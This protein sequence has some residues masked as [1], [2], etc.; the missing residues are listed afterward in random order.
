MLSN[1]A[2]RLIGVRSAAAPF[3]GCLAA[4]CDE[5]RRLAE[6]PRAETSERRRVRRFANG[7][8]SF[9][10]RRA[11]PTTNVAEFVDDTEERERECRH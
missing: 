2:R 9:Y 7:R 4:A 5:A 1:S 6:F 8:R 3:P 11:P 10:V